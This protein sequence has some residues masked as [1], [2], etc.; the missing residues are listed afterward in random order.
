MLLERQYVGRKGR[1]RPVANALAVRIPNAIP[2]MG[3]VG[4]ATAGLGA[5]EGGAA[6]D[7]LV[8]EVDAEEHPAG[9]GKMKKGARSSGRLSA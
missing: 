6:D 8:D 5:H 3:E 7:E 9:T 1:G 4:Y 2:L